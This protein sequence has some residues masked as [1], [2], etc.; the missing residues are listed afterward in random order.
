MQEGVQKTASY[1]ASLCAERIVA[2]RREMQRRWAEERRELERIYGIP[3]SGHAMA[4]ASSTSTSPSR[5]AMPS[6]GPSSWMP[7]ASRG[8]AEIRPAS[9]RCRAMQVSPTQTNQSPAPVEGKQPVHEASYD[10]TFIDAYD[11][12]QS[13]E[14]RNHQAARAMELLDEALQAACESAGSFCGARR[15]PGSRPLSSRSGPD[16]CRS[17]GQV[18][19][20][21][22]AHSFTSSPPVA[23]WS[24]ASVGLANGLDAGGNGFVA[25]PAPAAAP[26]LQAAKGAVSQPSVQHYL[27]PPPVTTEPKQHFDDSSFKLRPQPLQQ[28]KEQRAQQWSHQP[29]LHQ[30]PLPGSQ[31]RL[32]DGVKPPVSVRIRPDDGSLPGRSQGGQSGFAGNAVPPT[33]SFPAEPMTVSPGGGRREA[34]FSGNGSAIRERSAASMSSAYSSLPAADLHGG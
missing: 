19:D 31:D 18:W 22:S 16:A 24:S 20:A 26:L 7:P 27:P 17:A 13:L 23:G 3:P 15:L 11:A 32:Q 30:Q 6:S 12:V 14:E 9:E 10:S 28:Q 25:P 34:T 8:S 29:Q 21:V 33:G 2:A 1:C 4:A 5:L